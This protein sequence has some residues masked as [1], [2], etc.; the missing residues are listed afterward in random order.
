MYSVF[1]WP[2][3][4]LDQS[5]SC[6]S[7]IATILG[8]D[9]RL[10]ACTCFQL[11]MILLTPHYFHVWEI[12]L[13]IT[14]GSTSQRTQEFKALAFLAL[15]PQT[16][17]RRV[18]RAKY[19]ASPN[20]H[21]TN[22][23]PPMTFL[24]NIKELLMK[25]HLSPA[26]PRRTRRPPH[27]RSHSHSASLNPRAEAPTAGAAREHAT[28]VFNTGEAI[29]SYSRRCILTL[30]RRQNLQK[31][32]C[33]STSRSRLDRCANVEVI[34]TWKQHTTLL[35]ITGKIV[36]WFSDPSLRVQWYLWYRNPSFAPLILVSWALIKQS[37]IFF[38][39]LK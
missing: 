35:L 12:F 21:W 30:I 11:S 1:F 26:S 32:S 6:F 36:L 25:K 9:V 27:D 34:A 17:V 18:R 22:P 20:W 2:Y 29:L 39:L 33:S 7:T 5:R 23:R 31:A 14:P 15:V 10:C 16:S 37:Q 3:S 8:L 24:R 13:I 4:R 28:L 19:R 38:I